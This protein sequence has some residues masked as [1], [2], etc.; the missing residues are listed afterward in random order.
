MWLAKRVI[1][2]NNTSRGNCA[3]LWKCVIERSY[4]KEY[5]FK[6]LA[7]EVNA[8]ANLLAQRQ[9]SAEQVADAKRT[10]TAIEDARKKRLA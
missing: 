5:D 2:E 4:I 10:L 9:L 1:E 3:T 6:T 7:R 8:G